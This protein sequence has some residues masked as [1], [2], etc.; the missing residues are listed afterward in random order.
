MTKENRE[1]LEI[2]LITTLDDLPS[3]LILFIFKYLSVTERY[4]SFFDYDTRFRQLVKRWTSYSREALDADIQRFSTLHSWYKHLSFE[5][6]GSE[7]FIIPQVGQQA[8]YSFD[9]CINDTTGVHW[10][11]LIVKT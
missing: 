9:P 6:G 7:Y 1:L 11:C 3:E 4:E 2:K 8:R 10:C 5:N